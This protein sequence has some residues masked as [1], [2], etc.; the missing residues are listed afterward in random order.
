MVPQETFLSKK[1]QSPLQA[2]FGNTY[3]CRHHLTSPKVRSKRYLFGQ[4]SL[5]PIFYSSNLHPQTCVAS[6]YLRWNTNKHQTKIQTFPYLVTIFG[7]THKSSQLCSLLNVKALTNKF[8]KC[9]AIF[10]EHVSFTVRSSPN[11][12]P[13]EYRYPVKKRDRI[14]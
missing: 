2:I 11:H 5:F 12:T 3:V 8:Q 13:I 7:N 6:T 4:F 1:P 9:S 14:Q 10:F